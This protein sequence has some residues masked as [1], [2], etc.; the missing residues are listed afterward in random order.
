MS[1]RTQIHHA[2]DDVAPPAPTLESRVK[3]FVLGD[4]DAR[5][6]LRSRPRSPWTTRFRGS[7][8]LVAAGLVLALVGGLFVAGRLWRTENQPPPAISQ[9]ELKSLESRPLN[10]PT[11]APGAPCP[12]TP[13]TLGPY[14]LFIG[15]PGDPV[16][17]YD[18]EI[19]QSTDWG[20]WIEIAIG[21]SPTYAAAHPGLVLMRARD[22]R[23]SAE[24][25]FANYPLAPTGMSAVGPI[26]GKAHA[27]DHDLKL[28]S[29][30]AFRD[31]AHTPALDKQGHRPELLVV[32]G[33][34]KGSS[35]CIGFQIDGPGG[36][37]H[38]VVGF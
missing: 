31:L 22:L 16:G 38:L 28:R 15:D 8:T 20:Q 30:A 12:A 11:V 27:L 29:E 4:D 2:I 13:K 10:Y 35:G 18:T 23:D 24:V 26:L 1:L 21:Y 14:G 33:L 17:I 9:A 5:K 34:Q 19:Y 7:L 36:A 6:Q 32:V 25:V 37:E 3:N